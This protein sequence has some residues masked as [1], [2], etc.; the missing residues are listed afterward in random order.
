[1]PQGTSLIL[2]S[3]MRFKVD[4]AGL[5]GSASDVIRGACELDP[6]E[7]AVLEPSSQH[8]LYLS[9]EGRSNNGSPSNKT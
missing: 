9:I 7:P 1:M 3:R 5:S 4:R 6:S 2:G 8:A